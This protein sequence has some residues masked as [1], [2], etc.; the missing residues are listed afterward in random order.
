MLESTSTSVVNIDWM[1]I[2][3]A[4]KGARNARAGKVVSIAYEIRSADSSP[5]NLSRTQ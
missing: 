1:Q 2:G 4:E 3:K 5:E